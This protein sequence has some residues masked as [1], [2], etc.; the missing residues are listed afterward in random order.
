MRLP[1]LSSVITAACL[2]VSCGG[3]VPP[4]VRSAAPPITD[5]DPPPWTPTPENAAWSSGAVGLTVSGGH[6]QARA[7]ARRVLQ[8]MLDGDGAA[9]ERDLAPRVA[10]VIPLGVP[11]DVAANLV[12]AVT[13]PRRRNN[14]RLGT[15]LEQLVHLDRVD[16]SPLSRHLQN[17][18]A[19]Q[20]LLPTDLYVLIPLTDQGREIF[21]RLL[22]RRWGPHGA[23]LVRSGTNPQ[24]VGI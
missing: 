13:L 10:R 11:Q 5:S 9:L 16:V 7:L 22:G 20:G 4:T 3:T 2:A 18:A 21:R 1:L 19:P 12:R 8:A 24:I 17:R 6:D 23:M 14:L 15:P